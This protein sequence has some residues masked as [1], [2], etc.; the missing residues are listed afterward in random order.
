M[1]AAQLRLICRAQAIVH[2]CVAVVRMAATTKIIILVREELLA[3]AR[4]ILRVAA[5]HNRPL[6][7]D[8]VAHALV[9][10]GSHT[11]L[12]ITPLYALGN[13]AA[14]ARRRR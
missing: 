6:A 3:D 10:A 7:I 4:A 13:D 8:R 9:V 2:F 14:H 11:A 12:R 5:A 1:R